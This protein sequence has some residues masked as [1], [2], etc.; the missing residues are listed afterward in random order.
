MSALLDLIVAIVSHSLNDW[1]EHDVRR[2]FEMAYEDP[3]IRL[4]VKTDSSIAARE[5]ARG[6]AEMIIERM[7]SLRM[8]EERKQIERRKEISFD[9]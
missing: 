4:Y 7:K 3:S 9:E 6:A 1:E 8:E 2:Y 5:I